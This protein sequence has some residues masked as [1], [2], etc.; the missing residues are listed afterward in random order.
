[1]QRLQ[2]QHELHVVTSRQVAIRDETLRWLE[3][4]F[5]GV[6]TAVHFGNHWA[7]SGAARPKSHICREIGADLL[8]DD[9][10]EYARD[11]AEHDIQVLLYNWRLEYPW[12]QR[13][14]ECDPWA[15]LRCSAD[16]VEAQCACT[17]CAIA[18]LT[19]HAP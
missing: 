9:N 11:C 4:H 14:D 8:V 18:V 5:A 12:S 3:R 15:R 7:Q 1:M 6:F 17:P 2:A 19:K 16:G 13:P 10:P